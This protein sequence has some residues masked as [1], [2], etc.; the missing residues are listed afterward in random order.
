MPSFAV[1]AKTGTRAAGLAIVVVAIKRFRRCRRLIGIGLAG[2]VGRRRMRGWFVMGDC[3]SATA[4]RVAIRSLEYGGRLKVTRGC[5]CDASKGYLCPGLQR[6]LSVVWSMPVD[7][8]HVRVSTYGMNSRVLATALAATF[9]A[10]VAV[11]FMF[12]MLGDYAR[13]AL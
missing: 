2:S 13:S 4:L 8:T 9:V 3:L 5:R 6:L 1:D 7:K 12:V 11:M 10:Y